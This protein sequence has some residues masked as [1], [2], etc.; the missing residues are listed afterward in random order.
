MRAVADACGILAGS[1]YHHF[2]SKDALVVALIERYEAEIERVA[3]DA[4]PDAVELATAIAHCAVR[5]RGALLLTLY[6]QGT[7]SSDAFVRSALQP[8][9]TI[10]TA[11]R[12]TLQAAQQR[13]DLRRDVDVTTLAERLSQSMLHVG[14]WLPDRGPGDA[15]MPA[16]T[17]RLLLDG[18]AGQCPSDDALDHSAAFAAAN[19]AIAA[20]QREDDEDERVAKLLDVARAEFGR[21]G[22]AATTIRDVAAAA[23][24]STASIYRLISSKDELLVA[25]MKSFSANISAGWDA[26]LATDASAIEKLDALMWVDINVLDRFRAEYTIQLGWLLDSPSTA[27]DLG[28]AFVTRLRQAKALLRDGAKSGELQLPPGPADLRAQCLLELIWMPETLVGTGT[29]AALTFGRE[30]LLRGAATR[31]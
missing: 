25:I 23:G 21:R 24:L 20:W 22:F 29:R 30:T 7:D 11:M 12:K 9:A 1:L 2:A 13:G 4:G 27:V 6:E 5:H 26:V 10:V 28:W 17:S 31:S 19:A 8:P 18:V 15:R 14:M 3:E 16:I